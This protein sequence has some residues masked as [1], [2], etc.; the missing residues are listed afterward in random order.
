MP[1]IRSVVG[2]V[3]PPQV[4]S[5]A[6]PITTLQH[7][8]W[9]SVR[10]WRVLCWRT[11]IIVLPLPILTPFPNVTGHIIEPIS[12]G[13]ETAYWRTFTPLVLP[14]GTIIVGIIVR[15][16]ISP[17]ITF[18]YQA[19]TGCILSLRFCQQSLAYP[20]GVS[21]RIIPGHMHHWILVS[22]RILGY[23]VP[24]VVAIATLIE[25]PLN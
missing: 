22:R 8:G 7:P 1:T 12:I 13:R 5:T 3:S 4:V 2:A 15:Y 14:T 21:R 11:T 10:P 19:S 23:I 20:L 9:A 24:L 6:V 25:N 16:L 17:W 18:S